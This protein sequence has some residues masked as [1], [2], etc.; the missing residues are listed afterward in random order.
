VPAGVTM[1]VVLSQEINSSSAHVGQTINAITIEDFYYNNTLIIPKGSVVMGTII[2]NNKAGVL[3]R[4][5][6]IEISYTAVRTPYNNIIPITASVY[7]SD[8]S[9][10]LKADAT[11]E[12]LK[13]VAQTSAVAAATGAVAGVIVGAISDSSTVGKGAIYGS[14]L[15]LGLGIVKSAFEKG[16]DVII[17][18]NSMIEIIFE[19]PITLSAQ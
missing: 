18:A 8:L 16:E 1:N 9:G 11:K 7:T 3:Y 12:N 17:P 2:K 19:Q 4:D 10:V 14:A 15:G 6:K 13:D 5:G